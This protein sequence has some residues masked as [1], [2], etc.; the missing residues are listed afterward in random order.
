MRVLGI[1]PGS[2]KTGYGILEESGRDVK[3]VDSGVIGAPRGNL[4]VRLGYILSEIQ[5]LI[6]E[7]RPDAVAVET[8]FFSKNVKSLAALAQARGA[9]L[10]A[11]GI[12]GIEVFE[13]S[14]TRVKQTVTGHGRAAKEQVRALLKATL[15]QAPHQL[16]ASDALAIALCHQRWYALPKG[17]KAR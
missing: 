3:L 10:A 13:Y 1:D 5:K 16:D 4:A 12:A 14:P 6:D 17:G 8:V 7:F 11:A 2:N 15:G 9:A